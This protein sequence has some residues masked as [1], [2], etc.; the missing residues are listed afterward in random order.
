MMLLRLQTAALLLIAI[1]TI[2]G[3][4]DPVDAP[5]VEAPVVTVPRGFPP[6]PVPAGNE[7]TAERVALGKRLFFDT[8]LS[9]TGEIACGS[10]HLQQNAFAEPRRVSV[11][12]EGRTGTRNAPALVNLAYN[13]KFFWDGGVS[14]LEQ[15]AIAPII[16][17]LEMDMTMNEAIARLTADASYRDQFQAAYGEEP[18]PGGI[19]RAIASFIRTMVSGNSRYDRF[20]NGDHTALDPSEQRGMTMFFGERAECFHCHVGFNLTNNSFQNNG[21]QREFADAG[22]FLITEDSADIGKFKVPTLR[23]IAL[24]APYMHDGSL[25]TLEAVVE[26][27]STGGRGHPNTDPV[28]QPLRFSPQEAADMVAFLRSLTDDEFVA[29]A[30]FRK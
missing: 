9:R 10:C 27:Y 23:N 20:R 13:T 14:T 6:L 2:V 12:V 30:R 5:P 19:T 22:R 24:S 7:L 21:L 16:N 18:T 3:C 17:P 26:H 1:V 11:G 15:Q 28:I 25:P 4:S 8:R 29:N